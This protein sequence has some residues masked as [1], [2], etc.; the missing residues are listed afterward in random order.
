MLQNQ[1]ILGIQNPI[2]LYAR[3]AGK[4]LSPR[5]RHPMIK[6]YCAWSAS[7]N[8]EY[9]GRKHEQ[10]SLRSLPPLPGHGAWMSKK[11]I[12]ANPN[13][14]QERQCHDKNRWYV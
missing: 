13:Y 2:K 1:A 11:L 6:N 12:K 14:P 8:Q 7:A 3:A 10:E 4:K 9:Q 5:F